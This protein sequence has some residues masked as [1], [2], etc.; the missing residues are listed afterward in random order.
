MF[1]GAFDFDVD[2]TGRTAADPLNRSPQAETAVW[3]D[4]ANLAAAKVALSGV[5]WCLALGWLDY[6]QGIT[7]RP[8]LALALGLV[9]MICTLL[10]LVMSKHSDD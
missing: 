9:V 4:G 8:S 3:S 2:S 1:D 6:G 10:L 5:A 7:V